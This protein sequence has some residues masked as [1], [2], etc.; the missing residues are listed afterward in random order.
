MDFR[1]SATIKQDYIKALKSSIFASKEGVEIA[2]EAINLDPGNTKENHRQY[3]VS[4]VGIATRAQNEA[5]QAINEFK[6]V[7]ETITGNTVIFVISLLS[8]SIE[9]DITATKTNPRQGHQCP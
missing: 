1:S 9:L 3:L 4:L 7:L 5:R 8:S 6:S 2:E